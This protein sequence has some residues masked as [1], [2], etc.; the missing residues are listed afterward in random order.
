MSITEILII[1]NILLFVKL[2]SVSVYLNNRYRYFSA[3]LY[4]DLYEYPRFI[5][6]NFCHESLIQLGLNMI[7]FYI[8]GTALENIYKEQ[9]IYVIYSLVLLPNLIYVL[10]AVLEILLF[11]SAYIYHT[12][13]LGFSN[14]LFALRILYYIETRQL[15]N[16]FSTNIIN[17]I[18]YDALETQIVFTNASLVGHISG[19]ISGFLYNY[20]VHNINAIRN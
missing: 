6:S 4:S 17:L 7:G 16:Y 3:Y 12:P 10:I 8:Y 19:I 11:N 20:L 5:I 2:D 15:P 18:W 1:I 14:I 13:Q 9:F